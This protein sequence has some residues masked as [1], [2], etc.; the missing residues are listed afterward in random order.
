MNQHGEVLPVGG[1]N[2]KIE[3]YFRVC[4]K[5]GLNG[6]QGVLL[7][8]R[9]V[10]HLMLNTDVIHAVKNGQFHIVTMNHVLEGI[11]FLL[12]VEMEKINP[13]AKDKLQE[14]K[15]MIESNRPLQKIQTI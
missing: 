5:L 14:F 9:N 10:R 2:E 13:L 8:A 7:P 3:G 4:Q 11:A 12:N 6:Q 15:K 1:L